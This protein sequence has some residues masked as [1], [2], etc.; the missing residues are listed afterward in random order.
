MIELVLEK[1]QTA[2]FW[3]WTWK[4]FELAY[5]TQTDFMIYQN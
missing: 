2:L 4:I 1:S 5:C 3:T